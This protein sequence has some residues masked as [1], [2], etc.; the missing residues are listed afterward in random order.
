L[1]GLDVLPT[2]VRRPNPA[3]LL[4]GPRFAELLAWAESQYDQVL[5][6]C[7][8]VLAVSDAQIVGR[9]VD[10]GILVVRPDK[11]HRRL[12]MRAVD[13][14]RATECHMIGVVANGIS[15]G[16]SGYGYGYGYS[17]GYAYDQDEPDAAVGEGEAEPVGPIVEVD[18]MKQAE[19]NDVVPDAQAELPQVIRPRRAA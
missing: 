12:V 7:P 10:G 15:A 2:G 17:E 4:G 13:S 6:D 3:E 1:P 18:R 8:P 9:L 19:P 14:F 16:M 11:N 5:V